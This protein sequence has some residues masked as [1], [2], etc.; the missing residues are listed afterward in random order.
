MQDKWERPFESESA[1]RNSL[2]K[3]E[4]Y[5]TGNGKKESMTEG[6]LRVMEWVKYAKNYC[7]KNYE[8]KLLVSKRDV[9]IELSNAFNINLST[10]YMAFEKAIYIIGVMEYDGISENKVFAIRR[11]ERLISMLH[12]KIDSEAELPTVKSAAIK[13]ISNL[14]KEINKITQAY[15]IEVNGIDYSKW[16]RPTILLNSSAVLS[17]YTEE[18][19]Q[20]LIKLEKE[21]APNL[22][23]DD[24]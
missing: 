10:A 16:R 1:I 5:M 19:R 14:T 3:I 11:L 15:K 24:R 20:H 17:K 6:D 12:D 23:K 8:G 21:K 18:V 22:F 2:D 13:E 9:C 7:D 4:S